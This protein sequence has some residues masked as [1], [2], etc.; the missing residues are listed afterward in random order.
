MISC[1]RLYGD[2]GLKTRCHSCTGLYDYYKDLAK[3][4]LHTLQW[5]KG[6]G[7]A[8]N[9]IGVSLRL[10][11]AHTETGWLA[12]R[13]PVV[14]YDGS[15]EYDNEGCISLPG[16]TVPVQRYKHVM[17]SGTHPDGSTLTPLF[18]G[19]LPARIV[20]HELDHLNGLT[21]MDTTTNISRLRARAQW[22]ARAKAVRRWHVRNY[23]GLISDAE[24]KRLKLAETPRIILAGGKHE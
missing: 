7:I 23:P 17:L 11:I 21:I 2:S 10:M 9:Q 12:V 1:V 4:M 22:R 18:L 13:N 5:H 15:L 14:T 3:D 24:E 19:G 8:A 20:Q 16:I 6:V